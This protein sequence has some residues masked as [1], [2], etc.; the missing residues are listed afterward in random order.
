MFCLWN[1]TCRGRFP[2]IGTEPLTLSLTKQTPDSGNHQRHSSLP[3]VWQ[4]PPCF[5]R[6]NSTDAAHYIP[7]GLRARKQ[8][9]THLVSYWTW[10]PVH[11]SHYKPDH[12]HPSNKTDETHLLG[13]PCW[14]F[15]SESRVRYL[16]AIADALFVSFVSAGLETLDWHHQ[17]PEGR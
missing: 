14:N 5:A 7:V 1:E 9:W 17:S 10:L 12:R 16:D 6:F 2:G 13:F 15:Y 4:Q 3:G 11:E 8:G